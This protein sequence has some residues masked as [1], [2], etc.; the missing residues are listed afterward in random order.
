M[1]E[2]IKNLGG[3]FGNTESH[4]AKV[5]TVGVKKRNPFYLLLTITIS[6]SAFWGFSYT[7]FAP[8][9]AGTYHEVSPTLHVHP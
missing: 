4:Q 3:R 2:I 5:Q 8:V 6:F 9:I 7:Y 1:M